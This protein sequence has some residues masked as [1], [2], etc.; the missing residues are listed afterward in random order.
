M[1]LS[2]NQLHRVFF[3]TVLWPL[4]YSSFRAEEKTN[5][6]D[7]WSYSVIFDT[8]GNVPHLRLVQQVS[9]KNNFFVF[10]FY[11]VVKFILLSNNVLLLLSKYCQNVVIELLL[12]TL[13]AATC[14]HHGVT[15]WNKQKKVRNLDD[16]TMADG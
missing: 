2:K 12:T 8:L 4:V 1:F 3:I 6:N 16:W 14:E 10:I 7:N 11:S 9:W 5:L 13:Y 15:W